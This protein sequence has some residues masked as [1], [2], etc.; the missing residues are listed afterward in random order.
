MSSIQ[1]IQDEIV[2][3]FE[4]LGDDKESTIF[5]IMEL[6]AGLDHFPVEEKKE[7]IDIHEEEEYEEA[8]EEHGDD[9]RSAIC[10]Y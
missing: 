5:F 3:E 1:D 6:G 7:E 4:I 8:L 10:G 9:G 2:S